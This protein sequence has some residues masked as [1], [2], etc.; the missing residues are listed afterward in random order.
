MG[1]CC[2]YFNGIVKDSIQ[3]CK[4]R[5]GCDLNTAAKHTMLYTQT[6]AFP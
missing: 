5:H 2:Y 1:C 6:L 3:D 4:P